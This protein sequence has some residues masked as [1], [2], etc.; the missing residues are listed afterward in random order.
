MTRKI[1][2]ERTG[3]HRTILSRQ[4]KNF[5]ENGF[6][7]D[8]AN[9]PWNTINSYSDPNEMWLIWKSLFMQSVDKFAPLREKRIRHKKSPWLTPDLLRQIHKRDY[10]KKLSIMTGDPSD[11]QKFKNVRNQIS[12]AIKRA[13][14]DYYTENLELHKGNPRKTWSLINDLSSRK[15]KSRNI[16]ELTVQDQSIDSPHEMAEIFNNYFT[17]IGSSK[18]IV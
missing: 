16:S 3:S 12:N 10:L 18:L 8:L 6:L 17:N 1:H 9:K 11:W 15:C 2:L 5:D 13:K 4:Y 14:R 7:D